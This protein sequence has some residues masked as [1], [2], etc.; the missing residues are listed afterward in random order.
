MRALFELL[1]YRPGLRHL[2]FSRSGFG[3]LTDAG[4]L[5]V[6]LLLLPELETLRLARTGVTINLVHVLAAALPS[7]ACLHTIDVSGN[8][9]KDSCWHEEE[10]EEEEKKKKKKKKKWRFY[11]YLPPFFS[12]TC[13][14]AKRRDGFERSAGGLQA[15]SES[16]HELCC[17]D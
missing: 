11:L 7:C 14:N 5:G 1:P 3:E 13:V 6:L 8:N 12:P 17:P 4:F 15:A 2:D 16:G 10:E 9:L